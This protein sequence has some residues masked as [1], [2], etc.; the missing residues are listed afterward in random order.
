MH[1][2]AHVACCESAHGPAS[3][4]LVVCMPGFLAEYKWEALQR[5]FVRARIK[6]L[7][8]AGPWKWELFAEHVL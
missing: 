2:H 7:K 3:L 1:L 5:F 6:G 8:A 4:F